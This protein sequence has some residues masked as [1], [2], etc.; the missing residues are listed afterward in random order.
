MTLNNIAIACLVGATNPLACHI[1]CES[2]NMKTGRRDDC[3]NCRDIFK[4]SRGRSTNEYSI[5]AHLRDTGC[6]CLWRVCISTKCIAVQ[7]RVLKGF[8]QDRECCLPCRWTF[9][10]MQFRWLACRPCTMLQNLFRKKEQGVFT[11]TKSTRK[12]LLKFLNSMHAQIFFFLVRLWRRV[13]TPVMN[14]MRR[15]QVRTTHFVMF[16]MACASTDEKLIIILNAWYSIKWYLSTSIPLER[17]RIHLMLLT[18]CMCSRRVHPNM[19]AIARKMEV[20]A[21]EVKPILD[22]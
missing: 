12:R 17:G 9:F 22:F 3:K 21:C 5:K 11:A 18:A 10:L 16:N 7:T 2:V 6:P 4:L 19:V 14:T 1:V 8:L 13:P 15:V 20:C